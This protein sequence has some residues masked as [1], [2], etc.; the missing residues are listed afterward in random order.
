MF[1]WI[2]RGWLTAAGRL[3]Q[4]LSTRYRC[5]RSGARFPVGQI[6]NSVANSS[7]PVAVLPSRKAA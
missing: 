7:P 1:S 4:L 3:A 2:R 5:G 6:K